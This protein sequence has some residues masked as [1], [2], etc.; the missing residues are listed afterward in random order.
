[1]KTINRR[2][3]V[4]LTGLSTA[5]LALGPGMKAFGK[6]AAAKQPGGPYPENFME[7]HKRMIKVDAA[8]PLIGMTKDTKHFDWWI[9]GGIN[10]M[11]LT[12]TGAN[13]DAAFTNKFLTW[14]TEQMQTRDDLML[15]RTADDLRT[16]YRDGKLGV[17][18]HFQGPAPLGYG[19]DSVWYYKA[20]GV[21]LLQMAYN[22]RNPYANGITE[23]VDGG[24]SILGQK[25]V[26]TCNEARVIVDVSHT[27]PKSA[28][29]T[30]EASSEPVVI[31]HGNAFGQIDSPRNVKDDLLK[32][33]AESG[34]LAGAVGYPP[35]V[36]KNKRPSMEDMVA[37][38]DYMVETIGIDHV[39][40]GVDYDATTHGV[41]PEEWVEK[42]YQGY[43]DSGAWNPKAYPPPPYYYPEG[44]ELPNT[45]HN[46]TGAL[47]ARGYTEEDVAKIWGGN[48]LRVMD[49][50]WG[51]PNAKKV[52]QV[53]VQVH[54]R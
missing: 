23:R 53:D 29:D 18:F 43:V 11:S 48:W 30:I 22:T 54:E 7:I 3:F 6:E 9:D 17:F 13:L 2:D 35:F 41:L 27:G 45:L 37:M 8:C 36:S 40:I 5:A 31:S 25:L 38:V 42:Q 4:K 34:G 21:G 39:A 26:K 10:G 14:V 28:M 32:A 50:V 12:V 52:D 1:M 49:K 20:L 33:V 46:L 15:V 47:L 44:I 24:L 19:L 51:D 16:A